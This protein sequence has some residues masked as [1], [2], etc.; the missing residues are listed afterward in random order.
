MRSIRKD[1][2][3]PEPDA[4]EFAVDVGVDEVS[5][6]GDL[7]TSESAF[8]IAAGIGRRRVKL[9]RRKGQFLEVGHA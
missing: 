5:G 9:Q 6:C 2:A 4:Y 3:A 7:R 8:K 1:A